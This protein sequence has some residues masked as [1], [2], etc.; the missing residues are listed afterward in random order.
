MDGRGDIS[1]ALV[2][3]C[4]EAIVSNVRDLKLQSGDLYLLDYSAPI[5]ATRPK[6]RE[7]ALILPR[8]AVT[9]L[10]GDDLSA[11]AGK[12]LPPRGFS[13]L[14]RTQMLRA[15]DVA[16]LPPDDSEAASITGALAMGLAALQAVVGGYPDPDRVADGLYRAAELAIAQFCNDTNL[17]PQIVASMVGCSRATL[18]RLFS[19]RDRSVAAAIWGAR[20]ARAHRMLTD[21]TQRHL[22]IGEI[23][24]HS[25]F[26][27]QSTFS[28]MFRRHYDLSPRDL[29][30]Q[31]GEM[32]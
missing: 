26:A 29:R 21:R 23:A 5:R 16:V 12:R 13:G 15:A 22:Q 8:P 1:I 4:R 30:E 7:L 2:L 31:A 17:S 6:H 25:G 27:D 9:G 11:L 32:T 28:R 20:L 18:Y 10:L 24:F 3:G 19:A 14:L